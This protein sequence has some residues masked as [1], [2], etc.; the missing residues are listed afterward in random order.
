[1]RPRGRANALSSMTSRASRMRESGPQSKQS[2]AHAARA[3]VRRFR[4]RSC[5]PVEI[6]SRESRQQDTLPSRSHCVF[7]LMPSTLTT[8]PSRN[9]CP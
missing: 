4:I 3:V 2:G 7:S 6:V 5:W 1:M 9:S 8:R